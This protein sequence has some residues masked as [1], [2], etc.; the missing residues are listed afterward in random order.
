VTLIVTAATKDFI[1]QVADTKLT[2]I[3]GTSFDDVLVKTTLVDCYD[4]KVSISYT[5][6]AFIEGQRTDIW[7]AFRL[8]EFEAWDKCFLEVI[9]FLKFE[10]CKFTL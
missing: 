9:D 7:L 2:N 5:G 8:K 6:L 1:F 10:I 3:D 4:V